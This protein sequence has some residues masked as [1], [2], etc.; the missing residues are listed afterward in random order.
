MFTNKSVIFLQELA[1]NNNRE[2]FNAHK[3]EFIEFLATPAENFANQI[4]SELQKISGFQ[5]EIKI[6]RM[7]RDVRFSKNKTP[8]HTHLRIVFS[9]CQPLCS[10]GF[11]F[12]LE[13]DRII[14]GAGL[15][16]FT[17][18]QLEK[19]QQAVINEAKGSKLEKILAAI[20]VQ[21]QI[22]GDKYKKIPC[23]LNM[24]FPRSEL[25]RHKDLVVFCCEFNLLQVN[26][27]EL[28][29][30]TRFHYNHL[31]PLFNWFAETL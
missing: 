19:Y 28:L 24:D 14:W 2:W 21:Y 3:A 29:N 11:Y 7:N 31:L 27:E 9:C 13:S 17:K 22:V 5:F 20:P 10:P 4:A 25:L 8:Y 23:G 30:S 16:Q 6:F 1:L 18:E 26:W 15:Y 12:S